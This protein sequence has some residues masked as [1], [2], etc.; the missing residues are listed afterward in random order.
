ML[1]R[2]INRC[3]THRIHAIASLTVFGILYAGSASA[4][5]T[6]QTQ[7]D[8]NW[9][10]T[11]ASDPQGPATSGSLTSS[12]SPGNQV[13]AYQDINGVATVA[14][15]GGAANGQVGN[16]LVAKSIWS[17]TF[18][19]ASGVAQTY[20]AA[21]SIPEIFLSI[22]GF[23]FSFSP[24]EQLHAHYTI[25]LDV[26]GTAAFFS[27]AILHS[28]NPGASLDE[29]GTDLGGVKGSGQQYTFAPFS[30]NVNLGTFA[31]NTS[32]TAT[33]SIE[34][35]I[36]IPGFEVFASA[37]IGDPIAITGTAINIQSIPAVPEPQEWAMLLCG[38]GIISGAAQR[39]RTSAS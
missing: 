6:I 5:V 1:Q 39:R 33:Y 18:T 36:D 20:N 34:A 23:G 10:G 17:Q 22:S 2:T 28:G 7:A 30:G 16:T 31:S 19:N 35:G 25:R 29:T 37:S 13:T 15:D 9:E 26:D 8:A 4:I 3:T 12:V 24:A 11:I 21:L 32:F 38:L 27:S 14:V